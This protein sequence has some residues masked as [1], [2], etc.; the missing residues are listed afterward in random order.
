MKSE[1]IPLFPVPLYVT[2][3]GRKL[4]YV[5]LNCLSKIYKNLYRN[6]SNWTSLDSNV[7]DDTGL[8]GLKDFIQQHL[9]TYLKEIIS[10]KDPIEIYITQ[11]WVNV[12][13]PGDSHHQHTH[14]NSILSG[15]FYIDVEEKDSII[16]LDSKPNYFNIDTDNP[17]YLNSGIYHLNVFSGDLVIFPSTLN[18]YVEKTISSKS[19]ISLSFN[20]FIRGTIG[21]TNHL[22]QLHLK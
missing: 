3:I 11:S 2:N 4:S 10:P 14:P 5:E 19:R 15:V 17:S 7:L 16:F 13:N 20:T 1:V 18:H 9:E 12:N 8:F 6:N 21:N 22:T